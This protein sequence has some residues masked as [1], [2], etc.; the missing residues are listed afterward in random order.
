MILEQKNSNKDFVD[1]KQL[2]VTK[3][4]INCRTKKIKE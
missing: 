4:I 2:D 1:D 3:T